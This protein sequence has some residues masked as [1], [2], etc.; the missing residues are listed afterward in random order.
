MNDYKNNVIIQKT[1]VDNLKSNSPQASNLIISRHNSS[2][3]LIKRKNNLMGI[4]MKYIEERAFNIA[5]YIVD[6][7]ATVRQKAKT[8]GVSK[9]TV[10]TDVM[11]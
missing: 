11:K 2:Y 4:P 5:D 10:H 3:F 9:S 1:K 7:N 6:S 8:F